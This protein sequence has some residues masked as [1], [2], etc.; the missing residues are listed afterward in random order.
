MDTKVLGVEVSND[1][2]ALEG[3]GSETFEEKLATMNGYILV[4][5]RG[6]TPT[7]FKAYPYPLPEG[8]GIIIIHLFYAAGHRD[9]RRFVFLYGDLFAVED[10]G[11][12]SLARWFAITLHETRV[13]GEGD[14]FAG[15]ALLQMHLQ[16]TQGRTAILEVKGKS[17]TPPLP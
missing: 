1:A 11:R 16:E 14:R 15:I 5:I 10:S 17:L 12:S 3:I 8:K 4:P 7:A 9:V 6:G 2:V 13:A